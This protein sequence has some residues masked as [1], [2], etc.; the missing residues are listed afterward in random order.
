MRG[1]PRLGLAWD[2]L[3]EDGAR[4]FLVPE[5][6][7]DSAAFP[8]PCRI[9][10]RLAPPPAGVEPPSCVRL[11]RGRHGDIAAGPAAALRGLGRSWPELGATLGRFEAARHALRFADGSEWDLAQ[12]TRIMGVLNVTPDSFSDGGEHFDPRRACDRALAMLD[13]GADVVDVGGESTRPGAD[14]VAPEEEARRAVPVIEAVRRARPAARIS[15]DTRRAAVARAA[16]DAGADMLNDVSALGD[17]EMAGVA[18]AARCPVVLMHMRGT[19]RGMQD[20][21][22]YDDLLGEIADAL[23]ASA[24]RAREAGIPDARILIDPGIGFGKSAE[25]NESL[26]RQLG[27]LHSLGHPIL[28]GASRKMFVGRRT[29]VARPSERTSGSLAA[30]VAAALSGAALVRVHDVR[31]TREALAVADAL[32][33]GAR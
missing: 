1:A 31:A 24:T 15:I 14:S 29:G 7:L 26:L 2:A 23:A 10:R 13:E 28:V 19:P 22:A 33:A 4:E 27:A 16:L 12:R 9:V 17:P 20:D 32:R 21:T 25:G 11:V 5:R 8:L 18:A 3:A 6:R 30:A